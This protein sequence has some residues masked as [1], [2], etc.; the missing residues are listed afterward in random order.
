MDFLEFNSQSYFIIKL[1]FV[2]SSNFIVGF[3][4]YAIEMKY[5]KTIFIIAIITLNLIAM[6][7]L[8]M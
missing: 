1:I 3:F 8:F 6:L 2:I 7:G 4:L 5:K